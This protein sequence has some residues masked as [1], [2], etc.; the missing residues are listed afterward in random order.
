MTERHSIPNLDPHTVEG[1]GREW[2]KF[3]NDV[4]DDSVLKHLFNDYFSLVDWGALSA[5]AIGADLGCGSGRWARFARTYLCHLVLVDASSEALLVAKNNLTFCNN[6]SFVQASIGHLPFRD[7]S[8][9]FAYSLGVVHHLPDPY[10]GIRDIISKLKPGGFVLLYIYY[11]L[12][13]K[14]WLYRRLWL[15]TDF[16]RRRV[17]VLPFAARYYI[18]QVAALAVYWPLARIGRLLL[19]FG[20]KLKNW[21]LLFYSDK[22]FYVMRN[23]ALDRF[24]TRIE[25]RFTKKEIED[26]LVRMGCVNIK[27][28]ERAPFWVVLAQKNEEREEGAK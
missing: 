1:F 28:S 4:I 6:V 16:V 14:H 25:H 3:R 10:H 5:S 18:S 19:K 23:D 26:I 24:G 20:I 7:N 17:S 22:P 12:E 8:L 15:G 27:F 9:D 2:Q 13:N 11:A 21:P